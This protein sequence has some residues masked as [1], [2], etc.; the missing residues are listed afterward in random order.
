L[1]N[2][3]IKNILFLFF[4]EASMGRDNTNDTR[5]GAKKPLPDLVTRDE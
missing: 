1:C 5:E 2:R 3:K 4:E